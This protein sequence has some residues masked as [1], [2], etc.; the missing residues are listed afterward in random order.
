MKKI[1]ILFLIFTSCNYNKDTTIEMRLV[2]NRDYYP[3]VK[4]Q[5][6]SSKEYVY[7]TMYVA[8]LDGYNQV[9]MLFN[10]IV[11]AKERGVDIKIILDSSSYDNNLNITNTAFAESLKKYGISVKFDSP[12]ITTHAKF[13]IFDDKS[14]IIGSTN[15]T[16]SSLE[17][18]NEVN[19]FIQ[20]KYLALELK[21]Y[22]EK[23]WGEE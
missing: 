21:N 3:I 17:S 22:F 10:D 12:D 4:D 5:L 6:N 15:W 14:V 13:G 16:K 20:D 2:T 9:S 8:K 7:F 11:R 1:I 18:N 23:L 19:I